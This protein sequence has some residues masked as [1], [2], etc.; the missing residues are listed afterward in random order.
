M[1][2]LPVIMGGNSYVI[3]C[4]ELWALRWNCILNPLG[5]TTLNWQITNERLVGLL[6]CQVFFVVVFFFELL[7]GQSL[8][9]YWSTMAQYLDKCIPWN[10]WTTGRPSA[11]A[12]STDILNYRQP[13]RLTSGWTVTNN[14][15]R[16]SKC[17]P[18]L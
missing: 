16:I 13:D 3:S 2:W 15:E 4:K 10:M 6:G 11:N 9:P 18:P 1:Y 5:S 17:Q 14:T 12:W 7:N 8:L